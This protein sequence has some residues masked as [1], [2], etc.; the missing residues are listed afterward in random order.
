M[1][2]PVATENGALRQHLAI[3]MELLPLSPGCVDCGIGFE[4]HPL[5]R[6][7]DGLGI[8]VAPECL[9]LPVVHNQRIFPEHPTD[10]EGQRLSLMRGSDIHDAREAEGSPGDGEREVPDLVINN[11]MVVELPERVGSG[12]FSSSDA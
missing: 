3:G 2:N 10:P 1:P 8:E 4:L 6:A 7:V 11:L 5:E 9:G 12:C